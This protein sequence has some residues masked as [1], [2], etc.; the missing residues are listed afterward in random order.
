MNSKVSAFLSVLCLVSVTSSLPAQASHGESSRGEVSHGGGGNGGGG[1]GGGSGGGGGGSHNMGGWGGSPAKASSGGFFGSGGGANVNRGMNNNFNTGYPT[2]T[3]TGGF[4]QNPESFAQVQAA[5]NQLNQNQFHHNQLNQMQAQQSALTSTG[6]AVVPAGTV[7]NGV[8]AVT[9][10]PVTTPVANAATFPVVTG[11]A[12][13]Y[14]NNG[15]PYGY[16]GYNSYNGYNPYNLNGMA[17]NLNSVPVGTLMQ[18]N[19]NLVAQQQYWINQIN[20]G[21]L[22]PQQLAYAQNM[23]VQLQAQQ[24]SVGSTLNQDMNGNLQRSMAA[25]AIAGGLVSVVRGLGGNR[26]P[27]PQAAETS[28]TGSVT[29]VNSQ[30]QIIPTGN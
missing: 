7:P 22:T 1:N 27:A 20:S 12:Y 13:P 15:Y 19:N 3:A 24:N 23:L 2:A 11:A 9:S 25:S 17:P 14:G 30:G 18:W 16:N 29:G 5:Q 28:V 6:A 8:P 10:V 4:R 21:M 26:T